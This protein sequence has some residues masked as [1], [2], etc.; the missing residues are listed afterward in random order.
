MRL[1]VWDVPRCPSTF[2]QSDSSHWA[3]RRTI[4][5]YIYIYIERE[6]CMSVLVSC[7]ACSWT[8]EAGDQ[9]KHMYIYIYIYVLCVC[10]YIYIYIYI[11][12][13]YTGICRDTVGSHNFNSQDFELR[14]SNP[15]T[16]AYLHL[17][18]PFESSSLQGAGP[19]FSD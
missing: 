7:L 15:R 4:Y 1:R 2:E 5:M 17:S 14:V 8:C 19:M 9:A 10:A 11:Y 18:M 16:T 13:L 6:R 12:I 3:H